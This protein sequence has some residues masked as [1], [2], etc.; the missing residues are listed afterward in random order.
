MIDLLTEWTM[1]YYQH[2]L[3]CVISSSYRMPA[4]RLWFDILQP[5][6]GLTEDISVVSILLISITPNTRLRMKWQAW[7]L[8][9]EPFATIWT[10]CATWG[11]QADDGL[12]GT[13]PWSMESECK[14]FGWIQCS[15]LQGY[16]SKTWHLITRLQGVITQNIQK[17]FRIFFR[18]KS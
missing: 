14:H 2:V 13:I 17:R 9:S 12:L 8:L 7:M 18:N 1:N 3:M 15:H 11:F 16:F 6:M 4:L 10:V 5:V